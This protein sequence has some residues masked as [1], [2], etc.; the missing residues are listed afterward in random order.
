MIFWAATSTLAHG[1]GYWNVP[2]SF[3]QYI[4][5]G[6]GAGYHAPLLLGP[7][8]WEG[9]LATNERRLP[10]PPSSPYSGCGYGNGYQI[11]EP[12]VMEPATFA[13]VEQRIVPGV[14]PTSRRHRPL[15]LQ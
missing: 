7:V 12:T 11:A 4:G 3:C 15:F 1:A 5:Y 6:C 2:S 14:Q 13:P 8:S 10:Y 9:W